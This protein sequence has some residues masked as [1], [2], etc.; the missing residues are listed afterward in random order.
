MFWFTK[1]APKI[2]I[3]L[4]LILYKKCVNL[5]ENID[6]QTLI[7]CCITVILDKSPNVVLQFSV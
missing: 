5:G 1:L 2:P 4:A 7:G 6:K 3:F